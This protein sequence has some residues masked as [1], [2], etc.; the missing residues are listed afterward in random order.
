MYCILLSGPSGIIE[1]PNK[2]TV[3]VLHFA[4]R[5]QRNYQAPEQIYCK[6]IAFCWAV[7]TELSPKETF[8]NYCIFLLYRAGQGATRSAGGFVINIQQM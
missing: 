7:P 4:V 3:N 8:C 2:Y 6:R 1:L 5:S